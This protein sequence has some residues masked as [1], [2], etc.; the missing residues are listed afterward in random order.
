LCK[1]PKQLFKKVVQN[2]QTTFQKSC[3]KRLAPP[4]QKVDLAQPFSKVDL[5]QPYNFSKKLC[6]TFGSTFL[7]G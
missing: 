6:K 4:F 1:T 2:T 7:K 3:A 5:A